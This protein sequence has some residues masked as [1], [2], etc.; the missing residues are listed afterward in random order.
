MRWAAAIA[1]A[2][3]A[4]GAALGFAA[5][6][7]SAAPQAVV[8]AAPKDL[9][10]YR[11]LVGGQ[12]TVTLRDGS[13]VTLS[14][15]TEVR[16]TEWGRRRALTVVKGEAF[17][18]VA[19]NPDMPFVVTAAG[20]TVTALGTAF[21]VRVEPRRWSVGLLEGRIRVADADAE[22]EMTPGH[23]LVQTGDRPWTIQAQNVGD[24]TSWR[25]GHL[26]FENRPLGSIVEEMNRYSPRKIRISDARLASTP[27]S[28]RF[29][30]GDM[31]GFVATLEAYG[32]A[33]ATSGS[34]SVIELRPPAGG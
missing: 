4:G 13:K 19:R 17:F 28:G 8:I 31:D 14:T 15:D 27:L 34:P 5:W 22:V 30:T 32:V 25:E 2:V 33:T 26:V 21:D 7:P 24:L 20:R 16:L 11:T 29:R 10:V 1:V 9:A 23:Q 6:R 12:Q 3:L 18:E